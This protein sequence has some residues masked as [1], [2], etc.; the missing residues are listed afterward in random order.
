MNNK[1]KHCRHITNVVKS[2]FW[3]HMVSIADKYFGALG[4]DYNR[5]WE[6][7]D[8]QNSENKGNVFSQQ[9]GWAC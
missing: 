5:I 7:Y 3:L 2:G 8:R 9:L 4:I 1:Q 6:Q